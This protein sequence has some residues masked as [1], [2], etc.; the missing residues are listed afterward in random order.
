MQRYFIDPAQIVDQTIH[1]IGDDVHHI[2]T[3]M[4]SKP[5][6]TILVAD[7]TGVEYIAEIENYDPDRVCCRVVETRNAHGE[8]HTRVTIAQS[9]PKGDKFELILQ[10]GTELGASRFL[11]FHSERTVVKIEQKKVAKKWDRWQKI[12][13]E[14]AEQAHRG[15]VPTVET[16]ILWKQLLQHIESFSGT[17]WIAYEKGGKPLTEAISETH[18][19]QIMV[20]IGP[21]G[22]FSEK[23]I[24]EA[25][26]AGAIPLSLGNRILRTETASLMVLSCIFFARHEL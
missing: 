6:T 17:V 11:P 8:S 4:R 24:M 3:V 20:I 10:K 15:Q 25:K 2:K 7:G 16:P 1:I 18:E 9:M 19:D 21:E 14:A 5:G 22:G 13:K 26:Q 23:E 12:S